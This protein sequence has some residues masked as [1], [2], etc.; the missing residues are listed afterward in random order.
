MIYVFLADGF[1]EME[2]IAPVD[3]LRRCGTEVLTVS[4][5]AEREVKGTH[6]ISVIADTL[7]SYCNFEDADAVVLPGGLPGADNLENSK[8]VKEAVL[9]ANE[10][11]A[12]L[13]AICAAPKVLGKFGMLA[14]ILTRK[15]RRWRE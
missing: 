10:K 3:I 11:G 9:L 12:K 15:P 8:I 2:A 1:E 5:T 14:G 13:A 7:A 4:I 6:G